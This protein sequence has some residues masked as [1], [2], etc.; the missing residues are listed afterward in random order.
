MLT[1][2]DKGVVFS[3]PSG[4]TERVDWADLR[5][6]LLETTDQGPFLTDV[7]WILVGDQGG[8]VIPQGIPGEDALLTRLQMLDGFDNDAVI[9]AMASTSNQRFLCWQRSG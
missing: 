6:V 3:R 9:Q 2:S 7:F 1:I 4:P 8:C 5:A